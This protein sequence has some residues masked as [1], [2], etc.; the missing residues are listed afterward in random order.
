MVRE[1]GFA[2]VASWPEP[3]GVAGV[4]RFLRQLLA[5]PPVVP[6]TQRNYG[7]FT[8]THT[9]EA[10]TRQQCEFFDRVMASRE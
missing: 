2:T 1:L 4:T 3:E 9:A 7:L 8:S 6:P 10:R 5:H